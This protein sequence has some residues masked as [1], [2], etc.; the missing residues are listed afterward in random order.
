MPPVI[1]LVAIELAEIV[2]QNVG[3][4]AAP[5]VAPVITVQAVA[6]GLIG[7]VV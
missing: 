7:R 2:A 3:G 4:F 5:A 6:E 1:V